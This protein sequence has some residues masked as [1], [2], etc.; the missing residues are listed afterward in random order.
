MELAIDPPDDLLRDYFFDEW[1]ETY[2]EDKDGTCP[3]C[4]TKKAVTVDRD[5]PMAWCVECGVHWPDT[6]DGWDMIECGSRDKWVETK[7]KESELEKR[8]ESEKRKR[9]SD[10]ELL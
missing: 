1:Y 7:L 5:V 3:A 8:I 9:G 4:L 10:D 2:T 6:T